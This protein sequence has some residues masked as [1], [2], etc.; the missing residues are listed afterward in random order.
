MKGATILVVALLATEAS[1]G[2]PESL[3]IARKYEGTPY[4]E[5]TK[6]GEF[7]CS[8]FLVQVLSEMVAIGEKSANRINVLLPD[9]K[10]EAIDAL[11]EAGDRRIRGVEYA[12]ERLRIG[13]PIEPSEVQPGDFVQYWYRDGAHW[14]GHSGIVVSLAGA[15]LALYGAH[16]SAGKVTQAEMPFDPKTRRYYFV[17]LSGERPNAITIGRAFV[18]RP[19]GK[20]REKGELDAA[21][22]LVEVL[23][24]MPGVE[25]ETAKRIDLSI[26]EAPSDSLDDLV[27][28]ADPTTLGVQALLE[29]L[30]I[31]RKQKAEAGR[32]RPGDFVQFWIDRN[33]HWEPHC[34]VVI[35]LTE[36]KIRYLGAEKDPG[37]VA[38]IEIPFNPDTARWYFAR[39]TEPEKKAAAAER[40]DADGQT[41]GKNGGK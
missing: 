26:P 39:F 8:T 19:Y 18:G 5:A 33:E 7:V 15:K 25:P 16:K 10:P 38:E 41:D 12:L 4:G 1:A 13:K 37:K 28:K 24:R 23:R 3:R 14:A 11:V 20:S 30:K 21:A 36:K 40:D 29:K 9:S 31:G 22:F 32:I 6:K 27:D 17:R 35:R 2:E 34:G